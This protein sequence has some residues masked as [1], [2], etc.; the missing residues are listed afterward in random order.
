MSLTSNS[1]FFGFPMRGSLSLVFL[2]CVYLRLCA[3]VCLAVCVV[4]SRVTLPGCRGHPRWHSRQSTIVRWCL[5]AVARVSEGVNETVCYVQPDTSSH[6]P[7]LK[8]KNNICHIKMLRNAVDR[9]S[10]AAVTFNPSFFKGFS[11]LKYSLY[12]RRANKYCIV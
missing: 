2:M 1:W 5:V 12:K 8:C 11:R 7:L 6:Y 4:C 9:V 10:R 3:W